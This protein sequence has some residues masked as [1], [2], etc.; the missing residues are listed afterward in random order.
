MSTDTNP[1]PKSPAAPLPPTARASPEMGPVKQPSQ[2]EE[3]GDQ[4]SGAPPMHGTWISRLD[5]LAEHQAGPSVNVGTS[6]V[7]VAVIPF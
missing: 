6:G 1:P 2:G 5:T 7:L 4:T 3:D